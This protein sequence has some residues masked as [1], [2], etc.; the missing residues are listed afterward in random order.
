MLLDIIFFLLN[1]TLTAKN[2]S[3]TF[4][5]R[6]VWTSLPCLVHLHVQHFGFGATV[7]RRTNADS[8]LP[9]FLP[10]FVP[11]LKPCKL[12]PVYGMRTEAMK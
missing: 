7:N 4:V 10:R 8:M 2:A 3:C 5:V 6:N 12:E 11:S 1:L 9:S